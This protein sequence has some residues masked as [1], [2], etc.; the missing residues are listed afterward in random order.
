MVKNMNTS[1]TNKPPDELLISSIISEAK[2]KAEK[3]VDSA[4]KESESII[5]KAEKEAEL[6]K[7]EA[8]NKAASEEEKIKRRL[9][10]GVHLEIKQRLLKEREA[11][12]NRVIDALLQKLDKLVEHEIYIDILKGFILEGVKSLDTD[13]VVVCGGSA[14]K[15][16]L[17]HEMLKKIEKYVKDKEKREVSLKFSDDLMK[18]G[19]VL[20]RTVNGERSFDNRFPARIERILPE[21][22]LEIVKSF[23]KKLGSDFMGY[24]KSGR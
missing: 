9:L 17:S 22:R 12:I 3:I 4:E 7:K 18:S 14:E 13:K 23:E 24:G 10:S 21:L 16:L 11:L 2:L 8:F 20:L 6:K 5:S 1:G 15:K 19:G